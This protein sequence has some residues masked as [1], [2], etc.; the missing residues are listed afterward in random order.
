MWKELSKS[1]EILLWNEGRNAWDSLAGSSE[2]V[3][4]FGG[5]RELLLY[6]DYETK[7][8]SVG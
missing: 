1:I 3:A 6:F 5:K 8:G 2:C 7:R 4:S